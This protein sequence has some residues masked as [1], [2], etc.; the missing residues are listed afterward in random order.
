VIVSSRGS[1]LKNRTSE[2]EEELQKILQSV[3][4]PI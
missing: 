1:G 2:A 3:T 4:V